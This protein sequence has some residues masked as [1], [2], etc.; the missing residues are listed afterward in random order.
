MNFRPLPFYLHVLR[1]PLVSSAAMSN[2]EVAPVAG[3]GTLA[4]IE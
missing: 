1:D 2:G 3:N 4:G